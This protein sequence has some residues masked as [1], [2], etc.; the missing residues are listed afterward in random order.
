MWSSR[1]QNRFTSPSLAPEIPAQAE[2]L[3]AVVL[4]E[5]AAQA[6]HQERLE[7]VVALEAAYLAEQQILLLN[8]V[9]LPLLPTLQLLMMEQML[10]F[11]QNWELMRHPA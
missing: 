3:A 5:R 2:A 8:L 7:A 1:T 4:R 11:R 6:E 9:P 10:R